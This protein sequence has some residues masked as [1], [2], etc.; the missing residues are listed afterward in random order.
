MTKIY[1][2][3]NEAG[4]TFEVDEDKLTHAEQ[5]GFFPVVRRGNQEYPVAGK[6]LQN[7]INDGFEPLVRHEVSKTESALRGAAQGASLGLSDELTGLGETVGKTVFGKDQLVDFI[8]N[9]H[10]YRNQVRESNRMAQEA[11]PGTYGAGELVGAGATALVN[12]GATVGKLALQGSVQGAGFSE[13]NN[14]QD[15]VSDIGTGALTGT[16]LGSA[17]EGIKTAV[18]KLKG[19]DPTQAALNLV[20]VGEKIGKVSEKLGSKGMAGAA[21]GES[22]LFGGLPAIT[23]TVFGAEKLLKHGAPELA[24]R[25]VQAA[26]SALGLVEKY[27]AKLGKYKNVLADAA[28]RGAQSLAVTNYMLSQTDPEYRKLARELDDQA[29]SK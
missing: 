6:N 2:V 1:T 11:N 22:A 23:G 19:I 24:E 7:A 15:L 26:Q 27:G 13:A 18:D 17:G 29:S 4:D 12:P 10:T 5:D 16:V 20:N 14:T 28:A 9:Y 25:G 21:V 8:K 3:R